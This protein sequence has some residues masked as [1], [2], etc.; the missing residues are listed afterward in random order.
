MPPDLKWSD[1]SE[2]S[3]IL[4]R[5]VT[6]VSS[7]NIYSSVGGANVGVVVL[8]DCRCFHASEGSCMPIGNMQRV[9][10]KIQI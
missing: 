1:I 3:S 8:S 5:H 2:G 9:G 6:K 7:L 4:Y 10:L